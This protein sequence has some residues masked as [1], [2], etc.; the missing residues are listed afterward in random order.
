MNDATEEVS[1][2]W[3]HPINF[4]EFNVIRMPAGAQ[5]LHCAGSDSERPAVGFIWE[6]HLV[7]YNDDLEERHFEVVGTG[8]IFDATN[9]LYIGTY[10][11]RG[12]VWHVFELVK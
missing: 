3:K 8:S 10:E 6:Q 11:R 2:I 5:I 12:F 7:Q 9:A 1:T 4:A